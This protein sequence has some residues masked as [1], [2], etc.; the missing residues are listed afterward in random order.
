MSKVRN[1]EIPILFYNYKLLKDKSFVLKGSHIYFIQGPNQIGKTSFLT[2]LQGAMTAKDVTDKKVTINGEGEDSGSYEFTIPAADGSMVTIRNEFTDSK[3]K[4]TAILEDGEKVSKVSDIRALFN[5]TPINV[6]E[7][8][9]MSRSAEG[10]RKQRNIILKLLPDNLREQ[11]ENAD[12]KESHHFTE[13]TEVGR[14]RDAAKSSMD[15]NVISEDDAKLI[16]KEKKAQELLDQYRGY[17]DVRN[18]KIDAQ[19]NIDRLTAE[20]KGLEE[21]LEA[22]EKEVKEWEEVTLTKEPEA[23]KDLSDEALQ[24]K[25]DNGAEVIEHY[26]KRLIMVPRLLT[27]LQKS[28]PGTSC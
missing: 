6:S 21:R 14:D 24:E 2:A 27:G 20:K 9:A 17:L 4:F 23:T 8:F 15:L 28:M 16:G 10:R 7:F 25:I 19:E 3:N 18:T 5:Y 26:R 13:R 11:F 22:I 12:L 1:L